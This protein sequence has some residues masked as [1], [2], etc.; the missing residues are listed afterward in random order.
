MCQWE[1]Q[2][3]R[4]ISFIDNVPPYLQYLSNS[5]VKKSFVQRGYPWKLIS[6][7]KYNFICGSCSN[8]SQ[9]TGYKKFTCF[10]INWS[11]WKKNKQILSK[12][13]FILSSDTSHQYLVEYNW[14]VTSLCTQRGI[15]CY[16]LKRSRRLISPPVTSDFIL[17]PQCTNRV[18]FLI[19]LP[20]NNYIFIIFS[21]GDAKLVTEN[22]TNT[23]NLDC[24]VSHYARLSH[25][26]HTSWR[27]CFGFC[28]AKPLRRPWWFS[29][30][31]NFDF[32][33]YL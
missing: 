3:F 21:D 22:S 30:K 2:Y 5:F 29:P 12:I 18:I 14:T 6:T 13:K 23:L 33:S 31:E 8:D 7:K 16:N 19:S 20:R 9:V 15:R 25:A 11:L 17:A 24:P 32:F 10:T 1:M 28:L 26:I 27:T 4:E